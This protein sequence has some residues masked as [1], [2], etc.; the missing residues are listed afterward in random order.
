MTLPSG[1]RLGPYEILGPLGAGGMG[2]VYKA[3]DARLDRLV[4]IKVLPEHLAKNPDSLARFEREAKAVAAL[5]HSNITGLFDIGREGETVYAVMELLEGESL[6]ALLRQGP[7]SPRLATELAVQM[8]HGLA[9]AHDKGVVHR[10]LKPENLWVTSDGR[11]KILDF[12]LAKQLP[13]FVSG[14]GSLVPTESMPSP[15]VHTEQGAIL[16]TMGYMSPEQVRGEP[17][18]ARSDIFSFGVVLFEMLTGKRAFARATAA[19]TMAAV[20]KEDP[21][22]LD[23]T[24]RP[25][26][27]GLRR[28]LDH[29]LEKIPTRRFHDAH[30]LAFALESASAPSLDSGIRPP[31]GE[32]AKPRRPWGRYGLAALAVPALLGAWWLG[33][34]SPTSQP[35]FKR[36]TFG[37][38]TVESARFGP[39]GNEIFYSARWQGDPPEIF[40]LNPGNLQPRDLGIQN[41]SLLSVS[42]SQ[43]LAVMPGPRLWNRVQIGPLARVVPGGS[44]LR[45][46]LGQVQEA[47]WMPDG[48]RLAVMK[49]GTTGTLGR[50]VEFPAGHQIHAATLFASHLRVSPSGDRVA[51]FETVA[52]TM[53]SGQILVLDAKGKI[54]ATIP[55]KD[56]SGLAWG[57]GGKEI[58]YSEASDDGSRVWATDMAGHKRLLLAQAGWL[59]LLDVDAK[60]RA[61]ADLS[62][63]ITG[64]MGLFPP[65][66][67]EKDL[68]WNEAT[69]ATDFSPDGNSLLIGAPG[70][71]SAG[72]GRSFY[73][74]KRDGAPPVRLGE[75]SA[76]RLFPD[77]RHVLA[78]TDANNL[79]LSIVPV[80]PGESREIQTKGLEFVDGPWILPDGRQAV[81][82]ALEA[83]KAKQGYI[84]L[85]LQTG[86][87]RTV[88]DP[89]TSNWL[90]SNIVS[91]D[92]TEMIEGAGSGDPL[93]LKT[94]IVPLSGGGIARPLPGLE[95]GD[96]T[97]AWT[98]DGKGFLVF[99]RDGLPARISRIEIATGK[100]TL[101]REILPAN[102][103]GLSGI[104]EIVLSKDGRSFAYNYSRKLS[105]LYLIE[106]LR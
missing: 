53:D 13:S 89:G 24:S 43:E 41:A 95:P 65:D 40:S 56:F 10:D 55:S 44:G 94:N 19:D 76:F 3:K 104:R 62:Q 4:A 71:W 2:E 73:L 78:V 20:L 38:G 57:P 45:E 11:L 81:I 47:D 77:G 35:T 90:G 49:G 32:G 9:A 54:L 14:A 75:A 63:T 96:I 31:G 74:R 85:D 103:A 5:N 92:G 58:W 106:G 93:N 15:G 52:T 101:V 42:A 59:E 80:G 17:V 29:C 48:A 50:T 36:L 8:A 83:G 37:K 46:V 66:Y 28:V 30:D 16:G 64:V 97:L 68:S 23:E 105:D 26:P 25:I 88:G 100:R 34:G 33:K 79:R 1:T 98:P 51:L 27:P 91:P 86:A 70:R 22:D 82:G 69:R 99:N 87:W 12:G 102:P 61:V 6:R 72:E 18:D 84:L 7:L 39:T 67:R 60:G 21:P